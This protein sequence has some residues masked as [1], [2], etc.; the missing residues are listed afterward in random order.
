MTDD[1]LFNQTTSRGWK[2]DGWMVIRKKRKPSET[3]A[4]RWHKCCAFPLASVLS[5][6]SRAKDNKERHINLA[7]CCLAFLYSQ[8]VL[9][10]SLWPSFTVWML[11]LFIEEGFALA[12][13]TAGKSAIFLHCWKEMRII[14]H[15]PPFVFLYV[16][17]LAG[18][19]C[20]P[21]DNM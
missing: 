7:K 12:Q 13:K 1:L 17:S 18:I 14:I 20:R 2:M 5:Y 9:T 21:L 19:C 11:L 4:S 15:V 10:R 3:W 6:A 8:L 16:L